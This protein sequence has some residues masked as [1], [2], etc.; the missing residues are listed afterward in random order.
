MMT[1]QEWLEQKAHEAAKTMGMPIEG[2]KKAL[3]DA[4]MQASKESFLEGI[5]ASVDILA[6]HAEQ[7]N[8]DI[9]A[10]KVEKGNEDA[11]FGLITTCIVAGQILTE[12]HQSAK[13]FFDMD[14]EKD[15]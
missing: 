6:D 12:F 11:S 10:G 13:A 1:E 3:F 2:R 7:V 15:E 9:E 8:K 4:M 5:K 14:K